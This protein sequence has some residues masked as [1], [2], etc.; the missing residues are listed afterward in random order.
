MRASPVGGERHN[1]LELKLVMRDAPTGE[2]AMMMSIGGRAMVLANSLSVIIPINPAHANSNQT[3]PKKL[4]FPEISKK[5]LSGTRSEY[6]NHRE[7]WSSTHMGK[8]RSS[9]KPETAIR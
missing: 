5:T 7:D 1:S 2:R 8:T 3:T 4:L 9:P 6:N